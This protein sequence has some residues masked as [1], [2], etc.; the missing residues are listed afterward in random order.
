MYNPWL[1]IYCVL[2]EDSDAGYHYPTN[3]PVENCTIPQH[4][5]GPMNVSLTFEKPTPKTTEIVTIF[6]DNPSPS[7][8]TPIPW[9]DLWLYKV[10]MKSQ[11]SQSEKSLARPPSMKSHVTFAGD[12]AKKGNKSS[13]KTHSTVKKYKKSEI[14]TWFCWCFPVLL[15]CVQLGLGSY[16]THLNLS[17]SFRTWSDFSKYLFW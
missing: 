4:F 9:G 5:T 10:T 7:P 1:Q 13:Q 16:I 14:S 8:P 17:R 11:K 15:K 2:V 6:V 12:K 3:L